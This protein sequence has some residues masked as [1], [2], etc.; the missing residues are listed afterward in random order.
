MR[1]PLPFVKRF[2]GNAV[3]ARLNDDKFSKPM[4]A[5]LYITTKCNFRC[6]Y[7]DDGTGVLYPDV[8]ETERLETEQA[9][10][11][12]SIMRR[13]TP[14]F[15]VTGGEPTLRKDIVELYEH[16]HALGFYPITINTNGSLLHRHQRLMHLIDWLVISVDAT[17]ADRFD[18]LIDVGKGGQSVK[19]MDNLAMS[20]DYRKEH[21]LKFSTM[22][23]TVITPETIDDAWD[24]FEYCLE[25]GYMW[26]PMAH[27]NGKYPNAGLI[28]NPRWTELMDEVIRAKKAGAWIYGNL[29]SLR[30]MR[31]FVRYECYPS[32]R[33]IVYPNGD[34]LYPCG[35]FQTRA[36]NLLEVGDW[37]EAMAIGKAKHGPI[38]V[39]DNRCHVGCYSEASTLIEE[40]SLALME[41]VRWL[42]P[43]RKVAIHRPARQPQAIPPSMQDFRDQLTM[44]PERVRALR[45]AGMLEHDWTSRAQVRQ[46]PIAAK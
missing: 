8:P 19:V 14:G 23:N 32:T 38:P 43:N 46:V 39:C 20:R 41:A 45:A 31:D 36:A 30:V 18:A 1:T 27:I 24:V 11:V 16:I 9:K 4:V 3:R 26:S 37:Y 21:N 5:S 25:H 13:V 6:T 28:D 29:R 2:V 42:V 34:L 17:A 35:P 40:P 12:I 33:P 15:N 7:C 22:I 10:Q 44:P